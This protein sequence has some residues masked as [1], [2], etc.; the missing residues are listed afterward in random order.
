[1]D[2]TKYPKGVKVSDAQL[3]AVNISRH[4]FHGDWNY[5]ISPNQ[6]V[7]GRRKLN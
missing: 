1:L 2:Q 6:P 4:A 5:T 3:A 7:R